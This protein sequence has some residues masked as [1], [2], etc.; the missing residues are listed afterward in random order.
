MEMYVDDLDIP[1][2]RAKDLVHYRHYGAEGRAADMENRSLADLDPEEYEALQIFYDAK[3]A[4][5]DT[6]IGKICDYAREVTSEDTVIIV[7]SDHGE[8][9]GEKGWVGHGR[10][11]LEGLI[12]VPLLILGDIGLDAI[13]EDILIQHADIMKIFLKDNCSAN[14]SCDGMDIREC[15]RKYAVSQ[16]FNPGSL[17]LR[18]RKF[19]YIDG[20]DGES[21]FLLPNEVRDYS[22]QHS[23]VM[24]Y[25]QS[26]TKYYR[27]NPSDTSDSLTNAMENQLRELGYLE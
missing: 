22:E 27:T 26:E 4:Y 10:H 21:L 11:P 15:E 19:K 20:V 6:C 24:N 9:L 5:T 7:T 14:E 18:G 13:S 17:C 23:R 2:E 12:N 25:L 8:L 1:L 3:L 16:N